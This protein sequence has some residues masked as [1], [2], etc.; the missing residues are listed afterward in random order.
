MAFS[1]FYLRFR[2]ELGSECVSKEIILL[3]LGR[4]SGRR[5]LFLPAL[6]SVFGLKKNNFVGFMSNSI[7]TPNGNFGFGARTL[8]SNREN[9]SNSSKKQME[10][11]RYIFFN[12]FFC[13]L[14]NKAYIKHACSYLN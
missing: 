12:V 10:G 11:I 14:A 3:G 2:V 5:K 13:N 8:E 7:L 6:A 9:Y 1:P 4:V